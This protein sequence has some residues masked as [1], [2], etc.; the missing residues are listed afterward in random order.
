MNRTLVEEHVALERQA[1]KINLLKKE[2]IVAK[3]EL[4]KKEEERNAELIRKKEQEEMELLKR[5]ET[6]F[7]KKES[8]LSP[9]QYY[10]VFVDDFG[11][12]KQHKTQRI[13]CIIFW[14]KGQRVSSRILS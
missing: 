3:Q 7:K 13:F 12:K 5:K 11:T 6:E 8:D 10:S 4:E 1:E 2:I 14:Q 9:E